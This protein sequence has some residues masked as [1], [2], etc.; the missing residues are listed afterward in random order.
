[1]TTATIISNPQGIAEIED[2][3]RRLAELRGN[4]FVTPEW[5]RAWLRH[6]PEEQEPAIVALRRSSGDLVGVMPLVRSKLGPAPVYRFA[7]AN[8]GTFFHPVCDLRDEASVAETAMRALRERDGRVPVLVLDYVDAGAAWVAAMGA[9]RRVRA[10]A[11][12]TAD[13]PFVDLTG[14][15]WSGYLERKSANFRRQL[16]RTRRRLER[17]HRLTYRHTSS[18]AELETDMAAFF[19]LHEERWSESG[20]SGTVS[21]RSRSFH[22]DFT[23]AA[24]ARGWLRLL[25][26]EI[27]GEPA[28]ALYGWHLGSRASA[29]LSAFSPAWSQFSIGFAVLARAIQ[30]AAD[31][32]AAEFDLMIGDQRDKLRLAT[33]RRPLTTL[34]L[35]PPFNRAVMMARAQRQ[36]WKIGQLLPE[37]ARFRARRAYRRLGRRMPASRQR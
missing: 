28:A 6:Y 14:L 17:E 1:M 36:L 18:E 34:V 13:A 10:A 21:P 8:I 15:E 11:L 12:Q 26:M 22:S 37:S 2:A 19:R 25:M 20:G 3:W 4:A 32:G 27:D 7:G 24:L 5:F 30:A 31:E 33:E 35:G 23:R 29:A 9:Q 16:V